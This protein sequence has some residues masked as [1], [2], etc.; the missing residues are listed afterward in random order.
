EHSAPTNVT[1]DV[2]LVNQPPIAEDDAATGRAGTAV[3]IRVLSNDRDP[4]HDSLVVDS[5][6][7]GVN[8]SVKLIHNTLRYYP[9]I[10]GALTD[11]FTYSVRDSRGA[12]ATA[13]VTVTLTTAS[14]PKIT[15]VRVFPGS[16]ANFVDLVRPGK[17]VLPF[18][19]LSRVEMTFS[20][21]VSISA[22]DL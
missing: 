4:D 8:G 14:V 13:T 7:Q 5:F 18:G 10:R 16:S 19:Q 1:I 22:D 15:A 6:T 12:T 9:H 21:D 2:D 3:T 20:A 11:S 17:K